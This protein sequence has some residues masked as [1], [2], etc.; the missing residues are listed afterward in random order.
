MLGLPL[1]VLPPRS[2]PPDGI[3]ERANRT[4]GV[5]CWSQYR[6]E[7]TCAADGDRK[8]ARAIVV[9]T[10]PGASASN[11]R[12]AARYDAQASSHSRFWP[13][14]LPHPVH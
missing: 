11:A 5:E 6:G 7:L 13:A 1:L 8:R 2:P 12:L 14:V 10:S 3:V 9:A 4:M